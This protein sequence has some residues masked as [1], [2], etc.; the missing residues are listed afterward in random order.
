MDVSEPVN[1]PE[2]LQTLARYVHEELE[3][4]VE[5]ADARRTLAAFYHNL[6]EQEETRRAALEEP[7][8]RDQITALLN[9][10][11]G[12]EQAE[13]ERFS[14]KFHVIEQMLTMMSSL[15]QHGRDG[16]DFTLV[17][18]PDPTKSPS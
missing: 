12:I 15:I 7:S 17:I 2:Q 10:Y 13:S 9:K 14:A 4:A 5:R 6:V 1:V 11:E 18:N 3:V 8:A 16:I